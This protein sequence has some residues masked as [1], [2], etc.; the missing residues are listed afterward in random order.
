MDLTAHLDHLRREL[1]RAGDLGGPQARA[2]AEQL[3]GPLESAFR[4]ALLDALTAAAEEITRELAPGAVELRLRATG[5]DFVVTP[6][7]TEQ[8]APDPAAGPPEGDE[9]ATAR[10]NF[11]LSEQLKRRIE[12]AAGREGLSVNAWLVR[13]AGAAADAHRTGRAHRHTPVGGERYT[14]WVR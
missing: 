9:A 1:S 12:E 10:I 7:P 13:A 14:G 8:P 4:L 3:T 6:P 5:P 2:L 11:R